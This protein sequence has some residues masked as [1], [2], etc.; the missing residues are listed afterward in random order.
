MIKAII[1]FSLALVFTSS[2]A[3]PHSKETEHH[4]SKKYNQQILSSSSQASF[5]GTCEIEII[6]DSYDDLVVYGRFDDNNYMMPFNIPWRD[7]PHYVSLFYNG[8]CHQGMDFYI[9]TTSGKLKY[10]GF[11][12]VTKTI[13]ISSW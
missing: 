13:R 11:T 2:Y 4:F 10:N 3:T 7:A 6:N 12:P 9:E 5:A 8:Y 1:P